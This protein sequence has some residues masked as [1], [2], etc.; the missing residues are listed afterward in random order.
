[1][2]TGNRKANA[3]T[4]PMVM[5]A[6]PTSVPPAPASCSPATAATASSMALASKSVRDSTQV[7][8]FSPSAP[9][10]SSKPGKLAL[11][12]AAWVMM[13]YDKPGRAAHGHQHGEGDG[14]HAVQAAARQEVHQ[15][16][17]QQGQQQG[18][19][20]GYHDGLRLNKA[21]HERDQAQHDELELLV[22]RLDECGCVGVAGS[23]MA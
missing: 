22:H 19:K 23:F 15:R 12:C 14:H 16:V 9:T 8:S 17:Q 4:L 10:F 5:R 21:I 3:N 20:Q 7:S 2:N 6:P 1:M 11:K 13:K 18:E